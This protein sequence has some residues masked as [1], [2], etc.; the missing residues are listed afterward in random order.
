MT[1]K[2]IIQGVCEMHYARLKRLGHPGSAASL[3]IIGDQDS[4][5]WSYVDKDGP[6]PRHRPDLGPCWIWT[7]SLNKAGYGNFGASG[8]KTTLAHR[9]SYIN[10]VGSIPKGLTIDHLC[11]VRA[12][13]N[14][15]RHIEPVTQVENF[16][17]RL[18]TRLVVDSPESV[19]TRCFR[20]VEIGA[21]DA[22]P[23]VTAHGAEFP[24]GAIALRWI[25]EDARSEMWS[26]MA[27]LIAAHGRGHSRVE[28]LNL[29]PIPPPAA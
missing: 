5:F 28:L 1:P 6:V 15:I 21:P 25:G 14:Y 11:H 29:A 12:C 2:R 4:R 8:A 27:V 19:G 17:R 22:V 26:N 18:W 10:F 7:G 3:R 20:V 24:D 9:W 13:V 23:V 16:R